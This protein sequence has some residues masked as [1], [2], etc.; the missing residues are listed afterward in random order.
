MPLVHGRSS[1]QRCSVKKGV[2]R[3][4]A[5]FTRKQLRQSPFLNKV[6]CNVIKKEILAQVLSYEFCKISKN[7]FSSEHGQINLIRFPESHTF[8]IQENLK[9]F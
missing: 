6:A 1:H 3:N 9:Q 2:L 5:K 8:D 7:T 4:I